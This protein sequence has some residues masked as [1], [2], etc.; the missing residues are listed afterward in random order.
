MYT[1]LLCNS[2]GLEIGLLII[3]HSLVYWSV[4]TLAV[5]FAA[6]AAT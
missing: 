5:A 2:V 6:A 3:I 1:Q 4:V